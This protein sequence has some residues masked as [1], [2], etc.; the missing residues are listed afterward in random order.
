MQRLASRTL[1]NIPP[2]VRR[3]QYDRAALQIGMA[4]IGVGAF[5]R[6]HQ[7][8]YVD[9]MLEARFGPWG[10]VGIN[11]FPPRLT[12]LLVPQDCLYS[13]TLRDGD[14]AETRVIGSIKHVID[15]LD[16]ESAEAAVAALAAPEIKV[17]T[18]T[19]TEKGYCLIPASGALDRENQAL[20]AD[21]GGAFPPRTL[22]GL[23]TRALERRRATGGAGLTLVSCDNIPSNGARLRKALIAFAGVRSPDLA[24]WIESRV[25]FPS[26]MVDRIVPATASRRR[27]S[28][29][30]LARRA[31]RGRGRWRAVSPVGHRG[32]IRGRTAAVGP[33]RGAVHSRTPSPTSRSKCA[34]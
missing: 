15:V 23:L 21:L 9:D 4:H 17:A 34:F 10:L 11:L 18:M 20:E 3:P 12:D 7:A 6:C 32:R 14:H 28:C 33:C 1:A 31:R 27:R 8:E 13:R 24:P 16:A 30:G 5:H 25:A 19:V 2:A 22:L 26:T 29:V